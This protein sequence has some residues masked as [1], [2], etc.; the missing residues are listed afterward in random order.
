[1][2]RPDT[3]RCLSP[4][5]GT[6]FERFFLNTISDIGSMNLA[7]ALS[8]SPSCQEMLEQIRRITSGLLVLNGVYFESETL[9]YLGDE[10]AAAFYKKWGLPMRWLRL[11]TGGNGTWKAEGQPCSP[12]LLRPLLLSH[13]MTC[14]I[15]P[16]PK[17]FSWA[18]LP[19]EETGLPRYDRSTMAAV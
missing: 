19:L 18:T 10:E 16:E 14:L 7:I 13:N 2:N 9:R 8:G 4:E 6:S 11:G 1:M 15:S 5:P 12:S 3:I 17:V